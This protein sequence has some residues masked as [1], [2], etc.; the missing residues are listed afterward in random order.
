LRAELLAWALR[1]VLH[2]AKPP[3]R[4]VDPIKTLRAAPDTRVGLKGRGRRTMVKA[5]L[6]TE[7]IGW[8]AEWTGKRAAD[9]PS[10][11]RVDRIRELSCAAVA[12]CA[13]DARDPPVFPTD[14]AVKQHLFDR[15]AQTHGYANLSSLCR[16][17]ADRPAN[18]QVKMS[19][20]AII[21][22]DVFF[23]S[24]S[25]NYSTY[26]LAARCGVF[27]RPEFE[28]AVDPHNLAKLPGGVCQRDRIRAEML[29]AG[30]IDFCDWDHLVKRD[31]SCIILPNPWSGLS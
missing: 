16:A 22:A 10:A 17:Y 7:T 8:L 18:S 25:L 11:R 12:A 24:P 13:S 30:D 9:L 31:G 19:M 27:L 1:A 15:I 21:V 5:Q 28:Q 29:S 23:T 14:I 2:R 4:V 20:D 26:E 3:F 6:A